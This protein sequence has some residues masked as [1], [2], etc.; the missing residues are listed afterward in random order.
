MIGG[1]RGSQ[2]R[3]FYCGPVP[4]DSKGRKHTHRAVVY[5]VQDL[6]MSTHGLIMIQN[7]VAVRILL[8]R[9]KN[10]AGSGLRIIKL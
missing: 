5:T 10:I 4:N 7:R 2:V 8:R 1:S 3:E 6:T 9:Q